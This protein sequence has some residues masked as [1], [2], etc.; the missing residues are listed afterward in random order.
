MATITAVTGAKSAAILTMGTLATVT[1]IASSAF[2]CTTNNPLDVIVEIEVVAALSGNKQLVVF[3]I[4]SLDG[5]TTWQSGPTSS[6]VA[7]DESNLTFVGVV[8]ITTASQ[9]SAKAFSIFNAFGYI[10]QQFKLVVKND[11]GGSLTSGAAYASIVTGAS[12]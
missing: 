3:A 7:T 4:E 9:R 1:Y 12:A 5:G 6:N 10:P 2:D 8:P 11:T